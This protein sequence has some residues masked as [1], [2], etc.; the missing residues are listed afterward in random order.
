MN[1]IRQNMDNISLR[2]ENTAL[3]AGPTIIPVLA[4]G[5][6]PAHAGGV[7]GGR[8]VAVAAAAGGD[9]CKAELLAEL[10]SNPK[11]YDMFGAAWKLAL[12]LLHARDGMLSGTHDDIA[13]LLGRVSKDS[14]RNWIKYLVNKGIITADQKGWHMTLKLVGPYMT[15]ATAPEVIERT[16]IAA[17]VEHP[18][19]S[20][21]RKIAEGA[22]ML[23]GHIRLTIENCTFREDH[24]PNRT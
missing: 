9:R 12:R 10:M 19:L 23:G 14:V 24:D 15:A 5:S 1:D 17:T 18:K 8:G 20:A 6:L 3:G 2:T 13:R 16:V 11:T 4:P 7:V 21:I 22:D